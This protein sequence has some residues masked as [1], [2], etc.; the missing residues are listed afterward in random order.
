MV[1]QRAGRGSDAG[2]KRLGRLRGK[3]EAGDTAKWRMILDQV[4]EDSECKAPAKVGFLAELSHQFG[5][6]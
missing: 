6:G 3:R 1:K 5:W 4:K 2:S